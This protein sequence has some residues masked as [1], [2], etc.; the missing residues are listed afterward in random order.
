MGQIEE[1]IYKRDKGNKLVSEQNNLL[2]NRFFNLDTIAYQKGALS[3]KT[4]HLLGL[5]CSLMQRCNDCVTY[6]LIECKNCDCSIEEI[7]EAMGISLLIGG[8]IVIPELRAAL[9]IV[10]E[11]YD[12]ETTE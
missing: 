10:E 11:L 12:T 3:E 9:K 4:K 6:H 1:F 5:S 7:N 8:S 2:Y